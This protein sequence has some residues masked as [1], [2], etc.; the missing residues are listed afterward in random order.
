MPINIE[1][2]FDENSENDFD[3]FTNALS[4]LKT[5]KRLWQ[6]ISSESVSDARRQAGAK[7]IVIKTAI[8][9]LKKLPWYLSVNIRPFGLKLSKSLLIFLPDNMLMIQGKKIAVLGYDSLHM[10]IKTVNFIETE[11]V[12]QD[13]EILDYT[14]LKVNKDGSRDK[15]FRDNRKVP[16]CKYGKIFIISKKQNDVLAEIM[17]SNPST[18]AK[19]ASFFKH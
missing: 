9:L 7:C 18:L 17:C 8:T 1:Y 13:A 10:S 11:T 5:N 12:P 4:M 2:E 3:N 14:W 15:R 16:V 19:I 6:I